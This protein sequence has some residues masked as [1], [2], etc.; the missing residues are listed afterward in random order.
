MNLNGSAAQVLQHLPSTFA[1]GLCVYLIDAQGKVLSRQGG[2]DDL[3]F[4][5]EKSEYEKNKLQ[6]ELPAG[7][8]FLLHECQGD[9]PAWALLTFDESQST[10]ATSFLTD[11][12]LLLDDKQQ[13]DQDMESMVSSSM[14]LSEIVCTLHS[15]LPELP[16]GATEKMVARMGLDALMV[17]TSAQQ[18]YYLRLAEDRSNVEV[19]LRLPAEQDAVEDIDEEG[20]LD[21]LLEDSNSLLRRAIHGKGGAILEVVSIGSSPKNQVKREMIAV[22]VR[23]GGG[24]RSVTIGALLLMDPL[25]APDTRP[26]FMRLGSQETEVANSVASALGA[27]IGTR[28]V[29]EYDK[30]MRMA[31]ELQQQILPS[32]PPK[33]AGFDLAGSCETSGDVGGDYFD[34]LTLPDGRV[35]V[36][37]ADVS[38]HNL[39]SGMV[40]VSARASL[41]LLASM[42]G[43]VPQVFDELAS[44]LYKDLSRLERFITMVGVALHPGE[45]KIEV[46]N[47]GHNPTM[48]YR[49]AT[50]EVEEISGEDTVLGF[51]P[52][53]RHETHTLDLEPDDVVFLYTDGITEAINEAGEMYEEE[54]LKTA[55]AK[56]AG[57]T[58]EEILASVL[59]SIEEF[60]DKAVQGDD[61][62]AVV[63]KVKA[64]T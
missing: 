45:L 56:A 22:P 52:K 62:S 23:Y 24:G 46:A 48:V 47:A 20:L 42:H 41:R 27:A 40:M 36:V 38:G 55:L 11:L 31:Q 50:G 6:F 60:A 25:K 30:E 18:G 58:A 1:A 7:R 19:L 8:N 13:L 10:E 43:E 53:P 51:L 28:K 54:R 59:G 26:G 39:A 35:L 29:A 61:V 12:F 4:S 34:Y 63:V 33:L 44:S 14:A 32:G 64:Q 37:V 2:G 21:L 3:Q 9:K 57:G 17:A 16:T 15:L 49:A 5:V